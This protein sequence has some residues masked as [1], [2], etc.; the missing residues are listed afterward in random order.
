MYSLNVFFFSSFYNFKF[1]LYILSSY[2]SIFVF[3]CKA[4]WVLNWL[5][6]KLNFCFERFYKCMDGLLNGPTG[7][8]PKGQIVQ[9]VR[10]PLDLSLCRKWMLTFL[11]GQSNN[12]SS[13]T[14]NGH[15]QTQR[16]SRH[17]QRDKKSLQKTQ[18]DHKDTQNDCKMQNY[19]K[20]CIIKT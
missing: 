6:S 20:R 5:L 10:G 1:D 14:W 17:P 19:I 18:N 2:F 4:L 7:H 9:G 16:D 11:V 12:Y 3:S 13:V 15:N 8:M